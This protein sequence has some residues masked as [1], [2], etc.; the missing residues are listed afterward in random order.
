[1]EESSAV[2]EQDNKQ[3]SVPK[4]PT[5]NKRDDWRNYW[6]ELGQPWRTEPEIDGTRQEELTD[7]RLTLRDIDGTDEDSFYVF[8]KDIELTRADIEWLLATHEQEQRAIDERDKSSQPYKGLDLRGV[9]LHGK[10]LRGLNMKGINFHKAN[11]EGADLSEAHL[12]EANLSGSILNRAILNRAHLENAYLDGA[13]LEQAQLT[14]AHLEGVSGD[15]NPTNIRRALLKTAHLEGASFLWV[16]MERSLLSE[17][18]LE[19][20]YLSGVNLMGA[21]LTESHLEGADLSDAH[22]EGA[23][24]KKAYL[25]GANLSNAHLEGANL[26]EAHLEGKSITDEYHQEMQRWCKNFQKVLLPANLSGAFFDNTTNLKGAIFGDTQFGAISLADAHLDD[27]SLSVVDWKLVKML[28]DERSALQGKG[29]NGKE[30]IS[31]EKINMYEA[32]IRANHQLAVALQNQGLNEVGSYFAYRAQRNQRHLLQLQVLY[33][34]ELRPL[35]HFLV[36]RPNK[37][38]NDLKVVLIM[39]F[40]LFLVF[41][42]Y[43]LTLLFTKTPLLVI[44]LGGENLSNAEISSNL[45]QIVGLLTLLVLFYLII[46]RVLARL[47]FLFSVTLIITFSPIFMF[48]VIIIYFSHN[49]YLL[50]EILFIIIL[51]FLLTITFIIVPLWD[52]NFVSRFIKKIL[53]EVGYSSINKFSP[54]KN[55]L[56]KLIK[57][58][59]RYIYSS[60]HP[61]FSIQI[62]YGQYLFSLFL[63]MIA[64]YGHRP[65]RSILAYLLVIIIFA[66]FYYVFGQQTHVSLTPLAALVLSITSFHGRG[67]F[68]GIGTISNPNGSVPLDNPLVVLAAIEAVIGLIIEISFI[69][70]FTQRYLG[71]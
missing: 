44:Q 55:T 51:I 43:Q 56:L 63:D 23:S 49:L 18:H 64:G 50:S 2:S 66:S 67:F 47:F 60:F 12:E 65:R 9:D 54:I 15:L 45:H 1:M 26:N 4:H 61:F 34:L 62:S 25:H 17:A 11:L 38:F 6:N 16:D 31:Q 7:L 53:L 32:A 20:A 39:A 3:P 29:E 59:F 13:C 27:V 69:A 37:K 46:F 21:S 70:T 48:Y 57:Q 41:F 36:S 19:G 71:K 42:L 52:D 10:N 35:L 22:L 68:P 8:G 33:H 5:T 58:F 30:S 14:G 40:L 24:L 28:G